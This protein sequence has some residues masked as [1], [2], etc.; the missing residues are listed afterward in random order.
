MRL[1]FD[2]RRRPFRVSPLSSAC[3]GATPAQC[4][5][6]PRPLLTACA[7]ECDPPRH[8]R[9]RAA[10]GGAPAALLGSARGR[11]RQVPAAPHAHSLIAPSNPCAACS[12]SPNVL[13][14]SLGAAKLADVGFR[15][16]SCLRAA[17]SAWAAGGQAGRP[18]ARC[19]GRP[20]CSGVD[21][22]RRCRPPATLQPSAVPHIPDWR[23][24]Q[25]RHV[26][27]G[28]SRDPAGQTEDR[29]GCRHLQVSTAWRGLPWLYEKGQLLA[30]H[31]HAHPSSSPALRPR[32]DG[33]T[34]ACRGGGHAA[35][36]PATARCSPCLLGAP[37]S[38][39]HQLWR[40]AVV[41]LA[42]ACCAACN[43]P[44]QP[45]CCCARHG[46]QTTGVRRPL[47]PIACLP[48]TPPS[49]QGDCDWAAAVAGPAP[50]ATC[51]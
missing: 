40:A 35:P 50:P 10:A 8:V 1:V 24:V 2:E 32:C 20:C 38:P 45:C 23:R 3:H 12:K 36:G 14:S 42:C 30:K 47:Q 41:R 4:R 7:A 43:V 25:V 5:L 21:P 28:G 27:V 44:V 19:P 33:V 46:M 29:P 48:A 9:C 39:C 49:P 34:Q 22:A 31:L 11:G 37:H 51:A 6:L 15:W 17:A 13:L 18:G 16:A 26:C